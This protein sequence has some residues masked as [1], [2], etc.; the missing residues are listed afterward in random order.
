MCKIYYVSLLIA[1][2]CSLHYAHTAQTNPMVD[3]M[4]AS[5][6]YLKAINPTDTYI[7][8]ESYNMHPYYTDNKINVA[9]VKAFLD[10]QIYKRCANPERFNYFVGIADQDWQII[11]TD[12]GFGLIIPD[13]SS[14][15]A[16]LGTQLRNLLNVYKNNEPITPVQPTY[17][18]NIKRLS[19][20]LIQPPSATRDH[21]LIKYKLA[22][23]K[24][25]VQAENK[26]QLYD[27]IESCKAGVSSY[28]IAHAPSAVSSYTLTALSAL[29]PFLKGNTDW[30]E[31]QK[32]LDEYTIR[33]NDIE[34]IQAQIEDLEDQ[35]VQSRSSYM[36][37]LSSY[38]PIAQDP[39][40][41]RIQLLKDYMRKNYDQL[42]M[43]NRFSNR[44]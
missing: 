28:V 7:P 15:A 8:I 27:L 11:K 25:F 14:A 41:K 31:F 22:I 40:E 4:Q 42:V 18:L 36:S 43:L 2:L 32:N 38:L 9:H 37:K 13:P 19:D 23:A 21:E 34:L 1:S 44:R 6:G 29:Y 3:A 17:T 33:S 16:G 10:N 26:E 24:A 12:N 35:L 39:L 5:V 20:L 30:I